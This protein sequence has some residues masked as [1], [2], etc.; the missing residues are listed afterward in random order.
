MNWAAFFAFLAVIAAIVSHVTKW[1]SFSASGTS[2]DTPVDM[3]I[4]WGLWRGCV[5]RRMGTEEGTECGSLWGDET[6]VDV[7]AIIF[8][9]GTI[10][11][12]LVGILAYVPSVTRGWLIALSILAWLHFVVPVILWPVEAV[13]PE[14][15]T[16]EVGYWTAV[17]AAGLGLLSAILFI[18][19]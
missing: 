14:G 18:S 9:L 17:G 3:S 19:Q 8:L 4:Q 12:L 2:E 16:Y 7:S 13:P 15:T 11:F 10:V 1:S 5:K 6:V